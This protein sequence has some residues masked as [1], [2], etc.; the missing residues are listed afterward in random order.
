MELPLATERYPMTLT[1]MVG[2]DYDNQDTEDL[3]KELKLQLK[4]DDDDYEYDDD[5]MRYRGGADDLTED[6]DAL[7]SRLKNELDKDFTLN[8]NKKNNNKNDMNNYKP[9]E[10]IDVHEIKMRAVERASGLSND[11]DEFDVDTTSATSVM[12]GGAMSVDHDDDYY[13]MK[14]LKYKTKVLKLMSQF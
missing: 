2:G 4:D 13:K 9:K 1:D 12:A 8:D 10:K 7:I 11:E 6:T 5:Y 3:L 14:Y